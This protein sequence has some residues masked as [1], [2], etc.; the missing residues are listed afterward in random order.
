MKKKTQQQ[1]PT[2]LALFFLF[3][4]LILTTLW[5]F[6]RR[7]SSIQTVPYAK[8]TSQTV[9]ATKPR[10]RIITYTVPPGESVE[11]IAEKFNISVDTI[12]W[13]N[14]ID[15]NT[16][17]DGHVLRILPVTGISHRVMPGDTVE[18]IAEKYHTTAE[19]IEAYPFNEYANPET[20]VLKPGTI[21]IVPDGKKL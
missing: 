19:K 1:F 6:T 17:L 4:L 2:K 21:I 12:L 7:S 5:Q 8:E 13:E 10:D 9:T 16:P 20:F 15:V 11:M 3:F 18:S 14:A